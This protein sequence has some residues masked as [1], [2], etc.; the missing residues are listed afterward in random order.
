MTRQK[1]S[2]KVK[3]PENPKE[4]L[5]FGLVKFEGSCCWKVRDSYKRGRDYG[6]AIPSIYEPGWPIKSVQLLENCKIS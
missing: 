5:K 1:R 6:M 3:N 4:F 2:I